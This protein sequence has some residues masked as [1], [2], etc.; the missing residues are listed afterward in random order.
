MFD[1]DLKGFLKKENMIEL[2]IEER[3]SSLLPQYKDTDSGFKYTHD[4]KD[5]LDKNYKEVKNK[6]DRRMDR[7]RYI[8]SRSKKILFIVDTHYPINNNKIINFYDLLKSKYNKK[9]IS[10][11]VLEFKAPKDIKKPPVF[12]QEKLDNIY[13]HQEV[14]KINDNIEI[15]HI[16]REK[17]YDDFVKGDK[18]I[19]DWRF[20]NN[21]RLSFIGK[22]ILQ[23]QLK[24]GLIK[25]KFNKRNKLVI[26]ILPNVKFSVFRLYINL[27]LV[28]FDFAIGRI[29]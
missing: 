10:I 9:E 6:Y 8:I 29:K 28:K 3:G 4:F 23:R 2:A 20:L 11:K 19:P 22:Y 21:I 13:K 14:E 15:I 27:L 5:S 12:S 1:A 17:S 26:Y 18:D 7:L 24:K 25:I 16:N